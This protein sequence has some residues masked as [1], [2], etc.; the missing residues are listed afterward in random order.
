[1]PSSPARQPKVSRNRQ[2][3]WKGA[4]GRTHFRVLHAENTRRVELPTIESEETANLA[5]VI[6]CRN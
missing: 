4:R 6:S 3:A 1:M 2:P 5:V